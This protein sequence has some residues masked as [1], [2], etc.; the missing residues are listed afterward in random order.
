MT[1]L[2][3]PRSGSV[4]ILVVR[5]LLLLL[6]GAAVALAFVVA[7]RQTAP[8]SAAHAVVYTCA[9]HPEVRSS[10]PGECPICR[11]ALEPARDQAPVASSSG[12]RDV[13][14]PSAAS[15]APSGAASDDPS[16][17]DAQGA[18]R[19]FTIPPLAQDRVFADVMWVRERPIAREVVAAAWVESSGTIAAHLYRDELALLEVNAEG[20]FVRSD[21]DAPAMRVR[22]VADAA[23]AW[24]AETVRVWLHAP[25]GAA[26][27]GAIGW[28]R[29]ASRTRKMLAVPQSAVLQA[30]AGAYVLVASVDR[31]TFTRRPIE[32]GRFLYGYAPVLSGLANGERIAV[33]ETFFLDAE[34][35]LRGQSGGPAA[36]GPP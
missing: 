20:T 5:V 16:G 30:P 15:G 28:V 33:M 7:Q 19:R 11:M 18:P 22:L 1:V 8:A 17:S 24:D 10:A 25:P 31:R 21:G 3:S 34:R 2:A 23:K 13:G 27:V 35:R 6:A 4:L 14:G 9:M 26:P 36:T 32:I 12:A 29:F